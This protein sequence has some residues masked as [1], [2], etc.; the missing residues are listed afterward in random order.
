VG[1]GVRDWFQWIAFITKT[2][3]LKFTNAWDQAERN[4]SIYSSPATIT[5]C[6]ILSSKAIQRL[7]HLRW[8]RSGARRLDDAASG[9]RAM[10]SSRVRTF[11]T[12][13]F[14]A[15]KWR[16]RILAKMR[17]SSIS[18]RSRR[19]SWH[20]TDRAAERT[21]SSRRSGCIH[22]TSDHALVPAAELRSRAS[23]PHSLR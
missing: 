19:P 13:G 8:R 17:R 11:R 20:A 23:H 21:T 9:A 4:S 2:C 16:P 22:R 3:N 6:S 15:K 1:R 18:S 10:E 12:C 7:C 5:I 14:Q